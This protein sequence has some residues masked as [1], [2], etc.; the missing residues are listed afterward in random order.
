MKRSAQ[1]RNLG[2]GIHGL[3]PTCPGPSGLGQD[4]KIFY[5]KFRT[6]PGPANF[7]KSKT[8]SDQDLVHFRKLGPD[9]Q[10]DGP[11]FRG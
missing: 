11:W 5:E 8:D 4:K 10:T 1:K 2:S 7:E 6:R 9:Q 3:E